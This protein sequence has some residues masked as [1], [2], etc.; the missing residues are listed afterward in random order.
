VLSWASLASFFG[1]L[2]VA[3]AG[4]LRLPNPSVLPGPVRRY[5]VGQPE[6]FAVGTE[7]RFEKENIFLFRDT[8]GIYAVSSVCTHLGCSVARSAEGFSCPCHGSRFDSSGK[9]VGGPAPRGLPWLELG[10]AADGQIVVYAEREVPT[11][12]K[13]KV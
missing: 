12:T 7:T 6:H 3:L 2:G 9:V 1:S 13:F 8:E 4:A 10:R 11:G 5:K